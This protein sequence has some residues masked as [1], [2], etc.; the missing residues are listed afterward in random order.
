MLQGR[1][2]VLNQCVGFLSSDWIVSVLQVWSTDHACP[3]RELAG[4]AHT[5]PCS[6]I[7]MS[8]YM[9]LAAEFSVLLIQLRVVYGNS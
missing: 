2:Q 3:G 7:Q 8:V 6:R 9:Y 4:C 5:R 1:L